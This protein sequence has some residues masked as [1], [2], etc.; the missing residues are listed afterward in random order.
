MVF[1]SI[2]EVKLANKKLLQSEIELN[3]TTNG[4]ATSLHRAAIGANKGSE[5]LTLLLNSGIDK[6]MI[7]EDLQNFLH[8]LAQSD[9]KIFDEISREY[10]ELIT[11]DKFDKFPHDY[12]KYSWKP[13]WKI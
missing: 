11:R 5:S 1:Y 2:L 8:K 9:A 13:G 3:L 6:N 7:D 4:G 12:K 10:P